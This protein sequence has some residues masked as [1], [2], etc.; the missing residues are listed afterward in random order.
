[1]SYEDML[2]KKKCLITI[3]NKDELCASRALVTMQAFAD[4]NPQYKN[5]SLGRGQQGY[6][7]HKLCQEAGVPEGPCG[8]EELQKF[9]DHLGPQR[10]SD[11]CL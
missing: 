6:L 5:I 4:G 11:R 1:M 3:K 9:Q 10:L 8:S 7:A 2:K